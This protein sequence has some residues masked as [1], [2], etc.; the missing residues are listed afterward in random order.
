MVIVD[1]ELKELI[2]K[3]KLIIKVGDENPPFNPKIQIGP[4]SIDLRLSRVFRKYNSE[5]N[6]IDLTQNTTDL[7][8][9]EITEIIEIPF[10]GEIILYPGEL[11]L[12]LTVE[13]MTLPADISGLIAARSSIARLG[14][15]V[16]D[17]PLVHPGYSG[18]I[19]LQLRNNLNRPIK[20]RP[21]LFIC[22]VM[23]LKTTG[24]AENP[25]EGKYLYESRIPLASQIGAELDKNKLN[26]VSFVDFAFVTAL[27]KERDALLSQLDVYEKMQFGLDPLTY[28]R[29]R[30]YIPKINNYYEVVVITPLGIGNGEATIACMEGFKRWRP[31][32]VIMVGIAGGVPE[33]LV[34]GDVVVADF[35]FYYELAKKTSKGEQRRNQYF[36][37]NRLLYGRAYAYEADDWTNQIST[38]RPDTPQMNRSS[39]KVHFG[40]IA[41]G[42]K[43]L[44][45][46]KALAKLRKDC[47][48]MLAV[49]MEGAGVA[50]AASYQTHETRFLEIRSICDYADE[51]KNDIWQEYAAE[52]AAAF[53]ISFLRSG[54]IPPIG[55]I[56]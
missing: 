32:N 24:P 28:Y 1:K 6:I 11:Y 35:V 10:D 20:I 33:K 34:L 2:D 53:T 41:S 56:E 25:Y 39:P 52:V 31:A 23:F 13:T 30:I 37:S 3:K 19:A 40:A 54:P 38:R 17:Q 29:G 27:P 43:I 21:L 55:S 47:P 45:D 22:Q 7:I 4:S 12:G 49:A 16:V 46:G 14:L 36:L 44:A 26:E 15:S 9:E 48:E 42:D 5:T 51:G 50:G 8:G 18:A